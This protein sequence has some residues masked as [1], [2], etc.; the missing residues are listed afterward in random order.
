M[1]SGTC[2]RLSSGPSFFSAVELG[3]GRLRARSPTSPGPPEK[4]PPGNWTF[5]PG[6]GGGCYASE[7]AKVF[8][9]IEGLASQETSWGSTF[10][11]ISYK[12]D[13]APSEE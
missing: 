6:K 11:S 1:A 13:P 7:S 4:A 8:L 2:S 5:P 10:V 9:L 12:A 3:W